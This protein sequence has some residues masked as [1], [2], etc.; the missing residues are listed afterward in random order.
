[1]NL[2]N[3]LNKERMKITV[4]HRMFAFY[5][6]EKSTSV[7][8]ESDNDICREKILP[9]GENWTLATDR[10]GSTTCL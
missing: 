5:M 3:Y 1:M 8:R 9:Y 4:N 2:E 6:Q 7:S 10:Q